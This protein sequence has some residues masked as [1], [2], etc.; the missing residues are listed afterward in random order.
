MSTA[1]EARRRV[2]RV[3]PLGNPCRARRGAPCRTRRR[4]F[5]SGRPVAGLWTQLTGTNHFR[6]HF[7][8]PKPSQENSIDRFGAF[9]PCSSARPTPRDVTRGV[10]PIGRTICSVKLTNSALEV[11]PTGRTG[12]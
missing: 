2:I 10:A 1:H 12:G 11:H 6:L 8:E 5:A 7:R 3:K 9:P 4:G